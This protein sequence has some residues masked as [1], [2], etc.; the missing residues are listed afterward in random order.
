MVSFMTQKIPS[1]V[2][3]IITLIAFE[4][5]LTGVNHFVATQMR[6]EPEFFIAI[7]A[8]MF[9]IFFTFLGFFIIL[10]DFTRAYFFLLLFA[11]ITGWA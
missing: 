8:L 3:F 11:D 5:L 7:F 10:N 1:L 9:E 6:Q 2:C 4:G